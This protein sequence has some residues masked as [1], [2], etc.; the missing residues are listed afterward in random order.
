[1]TKKRN[2]TREDILFAQKVLSSYSRDD[3]LS[4]LNEALGDL[5]VGDQ[6][7]LNVSN[8][9]FQV[10]HVTYLSR[11]SG[12]THCIEFGQMGRHLFTRFLTGCNISDVVFL[13]A[14]IHLYGS[15]IQGRQLF[16][17]YGHLFDH[18]EELKVTMAHFRHLEIHDTLLQWLPVCIL[19]F[20]LEDYLDPI[21]NSTF[22]VE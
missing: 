13:P 11:L 15:L 6:V 8:T 16:T 20:V 3:T 18:Q 17:L 7:F 12:L 22:R 5:E 14:Q 9:G 2:C 10:V 21:P 19:D 1:M 4:A